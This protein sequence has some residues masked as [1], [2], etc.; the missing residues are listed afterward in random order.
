MDG[1]VS[2]FEA[3]ARIAGEDMGGSAGAMYSILFT[4]ASVALGREEEGFLP[5]LI[6]RALDEGCKAMMK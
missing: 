3:A 1:V 4:T 6:F 2:V 5:A